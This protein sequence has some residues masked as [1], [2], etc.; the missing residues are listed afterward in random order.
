M[1]KIRRC[2]KRDVDAVYEVCLKTGDAGQDATHLFDDPKALGHLFVGP[3]MALEPDFAFVLED[4][5]GVCGY[6]LAALDTS[7]FNQRYVNEWLPPLQAHYP[8]PIGDL[9][10]WS[11]TQKIYHQ[12]H[13]PELSFPD[14]FAPY[15]S[16]LHIDLLAR[17]QGQGQGKQM[18]ETLLEG[19][20]N[21]HSS[22]VHLGL[23]ARNTRA[24]HFY[25]K[26]GFQVLE[27]ESFSEDVIYMGRRF[28]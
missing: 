27:D 26:L 20:Q 3:Y 18:I 13:H 9:T 24:L 2:E 7:T 21:A 4:D 16:H 23:Y 10:C 15:P 5:Q 28:V 19:L 6:T 11:E 14:S 22:G 17:A 25:K 8:E 1:F 12:I